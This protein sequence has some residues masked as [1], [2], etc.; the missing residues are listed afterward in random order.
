MLGGGSILFN[1]KGGLAELS[2]CL[3]PV[4]TKRVFEDLSN[5]KLGISNQLIRGFG[6]P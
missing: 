3:L 4:L 1:I 2:H 5:N 6:I